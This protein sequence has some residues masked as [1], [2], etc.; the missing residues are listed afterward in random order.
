ME[1]FLLVKIKTEYQ[2]R[3]SGP[4][5]GGPGGRAEELTGRKC[6]MQTWRAPASFSCQER[7]EGMQGRGAR[8]QDE[9]I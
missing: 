6:S 2:S 1:D 3:R 4:E 8:S 9:D 7:G 5:A